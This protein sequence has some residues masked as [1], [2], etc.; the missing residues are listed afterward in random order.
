[1]GLPAAQD[2]PTERIWNAMSI[3]SL[4]FRQTWLWQNV[5][6]NP[7]LDATLDEQEFFRDQFLLMRDK[8]GHLVAQIAAD[9][10]G[11]TVHD[12]THLDSLW[13]TASLVAE[14]AVTVSPPE[15]F[16]LGA[17]ILL[18]DSAMTVAAYPGGLTDIMQTVQWRDA[19][20]RWLQS[21]H[22]TGNG[23]FDSVS[24]PKEV[25]QKILPDVLRRLHAQQ[26]AVLAEQA[27]LSNTGEQLYLI[28][29]SDL[30]F[31]YGQTIGDIAHSHWWSVQKVYE[32]MFQDLGAFPQRTR[33]LVDRVKIACLLRIADALHLDQLRAPRFLRAITR[34]LGVSALHWSF[35]EKLARPHIESDAVVFTS[36]RPFERLD[37]EAWWLAYDSL[38]L[39]DRE[40]RDVD[41]LL[42]ARGRQF[43]RARRVKGV[44]SPEALSKMVKTRDWRPV[45]A[46]IQVSDV[47]RIVESLGGSKLY[48]DDPLVPRVDSKCDRCR[49]GAT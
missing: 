46:R 45:D 26:A 32:E 4:D 2:E 33:N 38:S 47:P 3:A 41:L 13:E 36:G 35:Q 15:G 22:E 20:A 25:V 48:G 40:L 21:A 8:V 42:Q 34:P 10:P 31:F 37:A 7:R 30:R 49:P 1:M 29:D 9:M 17:S 43:L 5:F 28:S 16:V 14:G 24:P 11:M 6:V 27:W 19:L 39:V 23:E 12:L 44:G 18:H